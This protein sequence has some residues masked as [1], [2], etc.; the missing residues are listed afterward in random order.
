MTTKTLYLTFEVNIESKNELS[1]EE[2][3][4]F[5]NELDYEI[6]YGEELQDKIDYLLT[7][8]VKVSDD[9]D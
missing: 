4:H 1:Q 5:I 3:Q 9:K 8:L 7:E 6:L 2:I